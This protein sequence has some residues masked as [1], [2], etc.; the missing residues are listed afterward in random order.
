MNLLD[1]IFGGIVTATF[2]IQIGEIDDELGGSR[3][4]FCIAEHSI[5]E[6]NPVY[7][8]FHFLGPLLKYCLQ[9]AF[10]VEEDVDVQE[11]RALLLH[12]PLLHCFEVPS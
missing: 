5:R 2:E 11:S 7:S 4:C 1:T 9:E 10:R 8:D 6:R 12:P 3:V